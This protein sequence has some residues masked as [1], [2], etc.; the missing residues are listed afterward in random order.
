MMFFRS[1]VEEAKD[2]EAKVTALTKDKAKAEH[3]L[4]QLNTKLAKLSSELKDER[5]M[6]ESLRQNQVTFKLVCF[7]T[8]IKIAL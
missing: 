4:N 3:K 7:T 1:S 5:H 8:T 6:N 2:M